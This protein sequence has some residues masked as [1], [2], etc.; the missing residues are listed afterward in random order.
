MS[1]ETEVERLLRE[2]PSPK[3]QQRMEREKA[4]KEAKWRFISGASKA[5]FNTAQAEFMWQWLALKGHTHERWL[6]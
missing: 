5:G 3:E 2:L 6:A 4:S 1:I